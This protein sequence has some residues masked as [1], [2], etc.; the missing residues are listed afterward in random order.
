MSNDDEKYP[1]ER[2]NGT[3]EYWPTEN[4]AERC[5]RCGA[6]GMIAE[7]DAR[8]WTAMLE[9]R[10]RRAAHEPA[11]PERFLPRRR[12]GARNAGPRAFRSLERQA[13]QGAGRDARQTNHNCR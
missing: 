1:C 13:S 10:H 4:Q 12:R 5:R 2:C 11:T 9:G 3:G 6:T 8:A 7:A